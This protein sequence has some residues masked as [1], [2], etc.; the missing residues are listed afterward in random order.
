M[1]KTIND[2]I[3]KNEWLENGAM[4][5]RKGHAGE[6]WTADMYVTSINNIIKYS[7]LYMW[8]HICYI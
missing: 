8:A 3:S 6:E 2:S 7:N 4:A 5:K 1:M